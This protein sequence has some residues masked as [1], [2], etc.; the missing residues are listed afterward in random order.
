MHYQGSSKAIAVLPRRSY[1]G[2]ARSG[3]ATTALLGAPSSVG[4]HHGILVPP[5]AVNFTQAALSKATKEKKFTQLNENRVFCEG[6]FVLLTY[7]RIFQMR[8]NI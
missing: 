1:R 7:S 8:S 3:R 5:A 4:K 6:R 2:R